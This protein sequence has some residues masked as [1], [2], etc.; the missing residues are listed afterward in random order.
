[1]ERRG[2]SLADDIEFIKQQLQD[3]SGYEFA[4]DIASRM[5]ILDLSKTA[6]ASRAQVSHVTVGKWLDKGAKPR[7]KERLKELGMALG[8]DEKKF[9][10]VSSGK[11]LPKTLRKKSAGRCLPFRALKICGGRKYCS[12]VQKFFKNL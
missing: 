12:C 11:L 6:L 3:F 4:D 10:C 1:M 2:I 9:G 7:G 8:M 5:K